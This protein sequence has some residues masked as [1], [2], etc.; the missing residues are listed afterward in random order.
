MERELA[1]QWRN[2]VFG[3]AVGPQ[4]EH[5]TTA[6][7]E[8]WL[9][10]WFF[11]I[12]NDA[13]FG[14]RVDLHEGDW[15]MVQFRLQSGTPNLAV[16]AQHAYAEQQPWEQ[17]EQD[18]RWHCPVVYSGRG[19]HA[20]YFEAGLHRTFVK[21]DNSFLPLWWDAADGKGPN[22]RQQLVTLDDGELPGWVNWGG[23]WGGTR[24]RLPPLD[25]E[26]PRGPAQHGQWGHPAAFAQTAI[27]HEKRA[28]ATAPVVAVRRS[29]PGLKLRF[30]F[31]A[32]PDPPDRLVITA[33][34]DGEPPVTET[35]VVD[36]LARGRVTTRGPFDAAKA[37]TVDVST[38]S[39]SGVPSAP[40]D[41][42]VRVGPVAALSPG[43]LLAPLFA[44]WDRLWLWIGATLA[45][46]VAREPVVIEARQPAVGS[47]TTA[48]PVQ[49]SRP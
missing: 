34:P 31:T 25:G 26:S 43:K 33:T 29:G 8:V 10:Y 7:G 42:P 16:Y 46:R 21:F 14:G 48:E 15:E 5:V 18:G 27:S 40:P 22:I 37:Y 9:Q 4:G 36:A 49:V 12:Y 1:P 38:I 47:G 19:S 32:L 6:D 45:R 35:I 30:D 41:K 20:S 28:L 13:Q 24:P 23:L 11:Y 44:A 17:V 2:F 3:H 39:A